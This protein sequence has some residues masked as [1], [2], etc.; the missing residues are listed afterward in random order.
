MSLECQRMLL[1]DCYGLMITQNNFIFLSVTF[2]FSDTNYGTTHLAEFPAQMQVWALQGTSVHRIRRGCAGILGESLIFSP[3]CPPN[4]CCLE[5]V[6]L[7]SPSWLQTN[8]PIIDVSNHTFLY[9]L[10]YFTA[11]ITARALK[12]EIFISDFSPTLL[13]AQSVLRGKQDGG[14]NLIT[15]E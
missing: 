1:V 8:P 3:E 14:Q 15:S 7:C 11:F 6:S 12:I 5:R 4:S 2:Q 9:F 13:L 10:V